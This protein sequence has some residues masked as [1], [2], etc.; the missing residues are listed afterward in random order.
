[1]VQVFSIILDNLSK[2]FTEMQKFT[3]YG[4]LS[5]F[6]FFIVL[7]VI[8]LILRLFVPL[9]KSKRKDKSD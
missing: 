7:I 3:I 8:N 2:A 6:D 5:L 9:V 4:S 1:M